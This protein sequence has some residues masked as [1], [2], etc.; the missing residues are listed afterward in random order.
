MISL[1][2]DPVRRIGRRSAKARSPVL[3]ICGGGNAGHSLAV[4]ASANFHGEIRW[5]A[6][7]P[8]RAALLA[9][10]VFGPDGLRS[11]G[12]RIG[13]AHRVTM[14]SAD[15]AQVIAGADIVI[16]AAPAFAHQAILQKIAPHLKEEVL[17]GAIPA[18]SGFEF[19]ATSLIGGI[20]AGGSR[21][22]FGLQTLPWSTRVQQAGSVINFGPFKARVA[23]ATIPSSAAPA[24]AL[25]L[26]KILGTKL[27]ATGSF[28]NMTLGNPGQIIHPGLMHGLFANWSGDYFAE[29]EIPRLYA[30]ADETIGVAVEL[31]SNDVLA[32]ARDVTAR[33][34]G[35][36]DLSGVLSVHEWLRISYPTHI[37]DPATVSSCFRTGPLQARK[38]PMREVESGRFVPD[39]HYRYVSEDVPFG[40]VVTKAIAELTGTATPVLN[41]VLLWAQQ[42]LGASYLRN[43]RL[44]GESLATLPIPQNFGIASV[45]ALIAW[46]AGRD[47]AAATVPAIAGIAS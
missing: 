10:G 26:S 41:S 25:L 2:R 28:L 19:T 18:R 45:E 22:L 3:A 20:G 37:E 46:Y 42:R 30:D 34:G 17:V 12:N 11:T 39:F 13:T 8:E 47:A 9:A 44:A 36:I 15:P 1:N 31:L 43:G 35:A 23:M 6:S 29:N 24:A 40:L 21:T 16:I 14:V 5:L 7:S 32:V 33:S 27:I 4:L 38:A